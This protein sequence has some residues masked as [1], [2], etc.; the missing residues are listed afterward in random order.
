MQQI[1]WVKVICMEYYWIMNELVIIVQPKV[2]YVPALS[3]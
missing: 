3:W 2:S 1:K